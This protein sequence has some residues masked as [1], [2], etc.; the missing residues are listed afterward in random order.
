MPMDLLPPEN[1]PSKSKKKKGER[2][3][4]GEPKA[5]GKGKGGKSKTL[6]ISYDDPGDFGVGGMGVIP[7][8][9]IYDFQ[10]IP[11]EIPVKKGKKSSRYLLHCFYIYYIL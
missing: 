4:R 5:K 7:P 11:P 8:H 1:G 2:K 9:E 3:P 10:D 6:P